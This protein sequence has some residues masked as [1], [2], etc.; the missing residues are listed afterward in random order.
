MEELGLG[1][2]GALIYCMEELE[3]NLDDWLAE[4]LENY[5][6][7]DY[8]VFDCPGESIRFSVVHFI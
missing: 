1:P 7:D 5:R 6:D 4:E 8:L 3:D 2:N